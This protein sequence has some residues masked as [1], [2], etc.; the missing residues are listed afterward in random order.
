MGL[1]YNCKCTKVVIDGKE[2]GLCMD[3]SKLTPEFRK[4][5]TVKF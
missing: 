4:R 2:K 5:L 3:Q 1:C